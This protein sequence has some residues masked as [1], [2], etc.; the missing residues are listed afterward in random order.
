MNLFNKIN[1]VKIFHETFGLVALEKK[2]SQTM[3]TDK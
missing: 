2:L 3:A 1:L